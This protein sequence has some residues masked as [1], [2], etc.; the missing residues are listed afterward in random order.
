MWWGAAAVEATSLA[1][2][3][4]RGTECLSLAWVGH[5]WVSRAWF[6]ESEPW[7]LRGHLRGR[8]WA[9][10]GEGG[11]AEAGGRLRVL[12]DSFQRGREEEGGLGGKRQKGT[13]FV[14][15]SKRRGA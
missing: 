2:L 15:S 5:A 7:Q 6:L 3:T 9:E 1:V 8:A 11:G 10:H 4:G 13:C 12:T 14:W